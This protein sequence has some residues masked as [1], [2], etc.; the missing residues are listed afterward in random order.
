MKTAWQPTKEELE[1]LYEFQT[2]REIAEKV[3]VNSEVVR[4]RLHKFGVKMRRRGYPKS[5]DPPR[6]ELERLYQK[7]SM[8]QISR[9]FHVGE[10]TVWTRL[11]EHGITLRGFEDGGHRKK[12]GRE[13][14]R[15]HRENLSKAHRGKWAGDKNPNWNGGANEKNLAARRTGAYRQ[16]KLAALERAGNACEVC[17]VKRGTVCQCCGNKIT[18]HVH[19]IKSFAKHVDERFNPENSQVLC[20]KCHHRNHN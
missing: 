7:Y 5:F 14:S 13:F 6:D 8:K 1:K 4:M 16:W 11:K 17:G 2:C 3:G 15:A 9:K 20:P 18:L 12:P 19:H 10:T